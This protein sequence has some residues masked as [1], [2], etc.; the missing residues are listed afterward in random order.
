MTRTTKKIPTIEQNQEQQEDMERETE[1]AT[2]SEE[3]SPDDQEASGEEQDTG[4]MEASESTGEEMLDDDDEAAESPGE[5]QRP[6]FPAVQPAAD[7]GLQGLPDQRRR[8]DSRRRTL[9][10]CRAGTVCGHFSTSSSLI[11]Q[12]VVGRLANRLAAPP[13]GTAEPRLGF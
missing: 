9:R 4:E 5:A 6:D 13:D 12:G 2:G 8:R 3:A 1:E 10:R 11:L 7:I